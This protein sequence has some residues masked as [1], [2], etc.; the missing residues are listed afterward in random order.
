M[1]NFN[2]KGINHAYKH[3]DIISHLQSTINLK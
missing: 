2:R 1:N 3:Y